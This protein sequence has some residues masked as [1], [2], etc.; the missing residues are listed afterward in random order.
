[1]TQSRGLEK[2][3]ATLISISFDCKRMFFSFGRT[4]HVSPAFSIHPGRNGHSHAAD[5]GETRDR[6]RPLSSCGLRIRTLL[7]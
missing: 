3:S 6:P 5:E 4:V 1:M 2:N 7:F